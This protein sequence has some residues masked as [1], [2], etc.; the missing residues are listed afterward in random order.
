MAAAES[1][2]FEAA[3]IERLSRASALPSAIAIDDSP[4]DGASSGEAES[5]DLR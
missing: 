1:A 2:L 5:D 4:V 3:V